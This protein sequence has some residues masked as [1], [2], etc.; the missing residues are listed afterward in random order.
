MKGFFFCL[1]TVAF[2][3]INAQMTPPKYYT[4][5]WLETTKDKAVFYADFLKDG[6][7]Y[8]CTSYWI[9]TSTV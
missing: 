8:K 4:S 7:N 1:L 6:A 2:S 5:N 3:T 9:N